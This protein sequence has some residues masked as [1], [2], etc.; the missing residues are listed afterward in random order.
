MKQYKIYAGGEFIETETT[1]DIINPSDNQVFAHVFFATAEILE[2][3]IV[4]A[5]KAEKS[6]S[7]LPIYERSKIL[8]QLADGLIEHHE[9]F[10]TLIA[11]EAGKPIKY[12]LGE[13][14]RASQTF[15]IAAEECKRIEGEYM[16]LD[17]TEAGAGKEAWIKRYPIG[18]VAGISPFNFPLNLTAHKIAPAIASGN[19]IVLKPASKTSVSILRFAEL[20]DKTNLPEGGISILPLS[21]ELG[22]VL[23][24]DERIKLLSFTGS[25]EVGWAMKARA[26]KKKVLLELGGNAGVYVA[27]TAD[28]K[29]AVDRCVMGGFAYSGQVCIHVQRIYVE[30]SIFN[31]FTTSFVECTERLTFGDTLDPDTDISAMIDED[32]AKRV[33]EWVDDAVSQGA[34]ILCGGVRSGNYYPPTILT[35]T[36]NQ[37]KVCALEIFGPVVCLEPVEDLSNAISMINDSRYGLQAG[38]FTNEISEMNRAFNELEVGG[39]IIND[40]PTFR[41]DHMPYGGVKDSGLGREGVKFAIEEMT[42]PRLLVKAF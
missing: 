13:V 33:E 17:W 6:M 20:I 28:V 21:R 16:R 29:N 41:V 24:T 2:D 3:A 40:V 1:V 7:E 22:D 35:N 12:A 34:K 10:A 27:K 9:E 4:S 31:Q 8:T 30:K 5:I 25:P 19:P 26:G 15:L 32:N 37:M 36:K 11:M 14:D 42:E 23:V 18:L 38:I 39:V